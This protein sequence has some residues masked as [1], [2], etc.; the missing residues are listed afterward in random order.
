MGADTPY[1]LRK[2]FDV[3]NIN[4][5]D[6]FEKLEYDRK[7]EFFAV[8]SPKI[9]PEEVLNETT[10]IIFHKG[11]MNTIVCESNYTPHQMKPLFDHM[12]EKYGMVEFH[13]Y[14]SLSA[15][16]S[17]FGRHNDTQ[18]VMIVPIIGKIGYD[19]DNLGRVELDPGD[20]LYIPKYVHHE[21]VVYGPRV[22]LSFA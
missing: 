20:V 21:P 5:T 3:S 17:T 14:V 2:E 4:W 9:K 6:V 8:I 19:V 22:T 10:D 13:Q 1:L 15:E 18:D 11:E 12:K 16:S 7:H